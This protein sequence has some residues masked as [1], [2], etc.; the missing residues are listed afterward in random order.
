MQIHC[1]TVQDFAAKSIGAPHD[2]TLRSAHAPRSLP[3]ECRLIPGV[4]RS[5]H[6]SDEMAPPL[7][8]VFVYGSKP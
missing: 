6:E 1:C 4:S 7:S 2:L 5:A 3:R 8:D